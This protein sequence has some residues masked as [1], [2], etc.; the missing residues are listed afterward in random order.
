MWD[1][2][3]VERD[4]DSRGNQAYNTV[5]SIPAYLNEPMPFYWPSDCPNWSPPNDWL[6]QYPAHFTKARDA[7]TDTRAMEYK[8]VAAISI[9]R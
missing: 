8:L 4:V 9:K 5:D 3:G 2:A 1:A 7:R 6:S